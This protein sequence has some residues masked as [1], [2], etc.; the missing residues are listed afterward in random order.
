MGGVIHSLS[1]FYRK[2]I[3]KKLPMNVLFKSLT[4]FACALFMLPAVFGQKINIRVQPN[5]SL[6]ASK[7]VS[8]R[9]EKAMEKTFAP[10]LGAIRPETM[11]FEF[12]AGL[13][14]SQVIDFFDRT[15]ELKQFRRKE[16]SSRLKFGNRDE[17]IGIFRRPIIRLFE[18]LE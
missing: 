7:P 11:K 8:Y 6:L 4:A 13:E 16:I 18:R 17:F 15:S 1:Y 5:L 2:C 3:L 14:E 10:N 12:L 9:I